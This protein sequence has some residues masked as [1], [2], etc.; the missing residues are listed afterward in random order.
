MAD[1]AATALTGR[2][3]DIQG[4][5]VQ[6]GPGIRTTVF[7]KGCPLRCPWCHSP[8]SQEFAPQLLWIALK[9]LGLE[10]CGKCIPACGRHGIEPGRMATLASTGEQI[11]LPHVE[12]EIC[13]DC[14]SCASVCYPGAL[15]VCGIDYTVEEALERVLKDRPFYEKSGGGVTVSGGEPLCQIGFT[16]GLLRGLTEAGVHT[17]VDTTGFVPYDHFERILPYTDLFL[18]DIKHADSAAH[19]SVIGVPNEL[20]LENIQRLAHD[21]AKL[22]VRIPL[23]PRF[24]D[25]K[26]NITETI[27]IC[28][29]LGGALDVVQILPYHK[30]GTMKYQRLDEDAKVMEAIPHT[31]EEIETVR[32]RFEEAGLPVTVH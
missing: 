27:R 12:R 2:V 23:I 29:E 6:D 21:G 11:V 30:L 20:I 24:N 1:Q 15:S 8:E 31:E 28:T 19:R 5:T 18:Y 13:E 22:W 4:F 7:L 26:T 3:Y 25:D 10:A 32:R 14:G 9:C 17:A 16:E